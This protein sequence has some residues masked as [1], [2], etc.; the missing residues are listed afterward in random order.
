MGYGFSYCIP[1][2]KTI[3]SYKNFTYLENIQPYMDG[4]DFLVHK[5]N[6]DVIYQNIDYLEIE[7]A[8]A[9]KSY[10]KMKEKDIYITPK[11]PDYE[12]N[13]I[14]RK[15][16]INKKNFETKSIDKRNKDYIKFFNDV[17]ENYIQG[18]D[19]YDLKDFLKLTFFA[20]DYFT[21]DD[22]SEM[23]PNDLF[24]E[25]LLL[26]VIENTYG[27]YYDFNVNIVESNSFSIYNILRKH[28]DI[29]AI[30]FFKLICDYQVDVFSFDDI[31]G[32][33]RNQK[34]QEVS[35]GITEL[36][37]KGYIKK[38]KNKD[39]FQIL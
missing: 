32:V 26:R 15:Y 31:L 20:G 27:E 5:L 37:Q 13:K 16:D 22:F 21:E 34:V 4:L 2:G 19:K 9:F 7:E 29:N 12:I 6:T 35:E 8:T 23:A 3:H 24:Y 17:V 25:L 30:E 11:K 28:K 18:K 33:S 1:T 38:I 14:D 10:E 39:K 36:I